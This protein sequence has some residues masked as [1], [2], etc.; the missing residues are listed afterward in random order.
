MGLKIYTSTYRYGGR[1]RFDITAKTANTFA[2]TWNMVMQYKSGDMSE[3]KY[4]EFYHTGMEL[5][6]QKCPEEWKELL[7]RD[8]VTLVCFCPAGKFC[9]RVLLAKILVNLGAEYMGER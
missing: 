7:S 8:E 5:S 3:A 1:D 4:T 6:Q 2:P 9:H